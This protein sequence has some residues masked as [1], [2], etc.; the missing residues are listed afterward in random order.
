[1]TEQT[2]I[3]DEAMQMYT[4]GVEAA[5]LSSGHN[6][7]EQLRVQELMLRFLPPA[8][9]RVLDIGGGPGAHALWLAHHGYVV[10]LLD[11]VP[12]HVEQ[13]LAASQLQA[14][15]PLNGA[16]VG[17][18]CALPFETGS[19]DA[20]L[21]FGPLYHLTQ[22]EDRL[23][24][25]SEARRV[26]REGGVLLA[27]NVNRFASTF[28]G[29][30]GGMYADPEFMAMANQDLL[31]GQHR[32]PPGK[33]YFTTTFF[34]H[35]FE[36]RDELLEAGFTVSALLGVEGPGWTMRDFDE[37]WADPERRKWLIQVAQRLEEEVTL[38]GASAHVM[39]IASSKT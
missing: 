21:L 24:A 33:P 10:D 25:L 31:D 3:P 11:V 32:P 19:A 6:Q 39:A 2:S 36:L 30:F 34:H 29:L 13:A 35:P 27:M 37:A 7:L 15:T 28:D 16:V 12:L 4:E 18:A 38:L 22:R 23:K 9:A 5:R 14:E 8:P 1:M 17:D 20:V 26:L